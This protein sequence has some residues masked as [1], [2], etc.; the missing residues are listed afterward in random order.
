[1]HFTILSHIKKDG[2]C[3]T[4]WLCFGSSET[5]ATCNE[6]A[7]TAHQIHTHTHARNIDGVQPQHDWKLILQWC[8]SFLWKYV[9][10]G[11]FLFFLMCK[12][13]LSVAN[14]RLQ[15]MLLCTH[16]FMWSTFCQ[17]LLVNRQVIPP[18]FLCMCVYAIDRMQ[19]FFSI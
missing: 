13:V 19:F 10:F 12:W 7:S 17:S 5:I 4:Y 9:V 18:F 6:S 3:V 8:A 14:M 15:R 1:M 16:S 2:Y 11:V